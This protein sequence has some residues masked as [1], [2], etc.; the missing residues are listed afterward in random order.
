MPF[1]IGE[2]HLKNRLAL[3]VHLHDIH[4]PIKDLV[5]ALDDDALLLQV[6]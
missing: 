2:R 1:L 3:R 6:P 5:S 4:G